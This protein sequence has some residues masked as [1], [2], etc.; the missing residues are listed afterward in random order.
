[1]V[2]FGFEPDLSAEQLEL[3]ADVRRLELDKLRGCRLGCDATAGARL[4]ALVAELPAPCCALLGPG[5][6]HYLTR[7]LLEREREPFALV[8]FDNHSDAIG[9]DWGDGMLR[10]DG[11]V[12]RPGEVGALR[13]LLWVGV[14]EGQDSARRLGWGAAGCIV[15]HGSVDGA[16][17][18][19]LGAL[20][21]Y[22]SI[23]KDVLGLEDAA[24]GW[25]Q[26]SMPLDAL[27][28]G[29]RALLRGR[30]LVGIDVTGELSDAPARSLDPSWRAGRARN[31]KANRAIVECVRE[32]T[33]SVGGRAADPL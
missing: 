2:V 13:K 33:G 9:G 22:V 27:L 25:S 12:P 31:L 18:D 11:W 8:L 7:L 10:C 24:T 21:I 28:D 1:V 5:E 19:W 26:G 20:P 15:P 4:R 30:R 6:Y 16:L 17:A 3:A 14:T 32:I 29:L 23:D